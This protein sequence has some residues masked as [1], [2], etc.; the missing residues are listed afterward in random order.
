MCPIQTQALAKCEPSP[1]G[2]QERGRCRVLENRMRTRPEWPSKTTQAGQA[3]AVLRSQ[4]RGWRPHLHS[5]LQTILLSPKFHCTE[6]ILTIVSLLSVDS[7][8]Y[9]PPSRRD[10]VQAMRKKFLSSEGDHI[11]LLNIYRTFKSLGGDKV[12]CSPSL[13]VAPPPHLST[14]LST[15]LPCGRQEGA[16]ASVD[17]SSTCVPLVL[18][19]AEALELVAELLSYKMS[20][21]HLPWPFFIVMFA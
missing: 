19:G 1:W 18:S 14:G 13:S 20:F 9:N 7:V 21:F 17:S 12:L 3:G 8:L 2:M 15:C 16:E 11:T 5:H 10:E 6:E 4:E